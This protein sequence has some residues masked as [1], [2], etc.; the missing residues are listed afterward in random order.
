M[1]TAAVIH[2]FGGIESLHLRTLPV[3]EVGPDQVLI[4][5]VAAG[6]G[7]GKLVLQTSEQ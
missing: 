3:P 2:E 6:L 4:H 1:M 7:S 5:V